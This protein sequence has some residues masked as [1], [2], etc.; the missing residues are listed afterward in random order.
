MKHCKGT[1]YFANHL[2]DKTQAQM[3]D[4]LRDIVE[5]EMQSPFTQA[6]GAKRA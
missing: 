6:R 2:I 5:Y 1:E 4:K 3:F